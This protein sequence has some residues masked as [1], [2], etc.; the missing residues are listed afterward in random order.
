MMLLLLRRPI[1]K[2]ATFC[3]FREEGIET[4]SRLWQLETLLT[5]LPPSVAAIGQNVFQTCY[6]ADIFPSLSYFTV[7]QK[8]TDTL[9]VAAVYSCETP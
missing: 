5:P 7:H 8:S 6:K 2:S 1:R 9:K 3:A 4:A